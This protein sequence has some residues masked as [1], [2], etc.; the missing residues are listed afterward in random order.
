MDVL[1]S[2]YNFF[3]GWFFE[4]GTVTLEAFAE[5]FWLSR[6]VPES[7]MNNA[8]Y[9]VHLISWYKCRNDP[10]VLLL[11]FEDLKE[12]LGMQVRRVAKFMSTPKH[13][14]TTDDIVKGAVHRSSFEFMKMHQSQFDEKLSKLTRN[15]E[16]GLPK[17]A[18][19][20]ESKLK[21]GD[22][23]IGKTRLPPFI[24]EEITKKW[25]EVVEPVTGCATYDELRTTVAAE[26]KRSSI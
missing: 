26:N 18:G 14:F 10:N 2:F 4:V 21:R 5:E 15:E 20:S 17:N 12:D 3:E 24:Q 23:G 8:S 9:F 11:F 7:K 22:S 19:L 25:K 6:G 1:L 13:D 16:C